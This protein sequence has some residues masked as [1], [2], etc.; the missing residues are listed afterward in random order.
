MSDD[1]WDRDDIEIPAAP[2][3][4]NWDDEE[5]EEVKVVFL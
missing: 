5:E 1:E 2:T 3:K 4:S